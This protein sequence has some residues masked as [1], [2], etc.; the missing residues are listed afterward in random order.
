MYAKELEDEPCTQ[1]DRDRI[2]AAAKER[3]FKINTL[4]DE[5]EYYGRHYWRPQT[6]AE[7]AATRIAMLDAAAQLRQLA[8]GK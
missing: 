5:L 4:C 8:E 1:E 3:V 6:F 2:R 7:D